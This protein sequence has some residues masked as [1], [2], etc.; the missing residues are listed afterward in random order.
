M[1][2][3]NVAIVQQQQQNMMILI[4]IAE[5]YCICLRSFGIQLKRLSFIFIQN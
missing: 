1:D 5:N 3:I 2:D 4:E